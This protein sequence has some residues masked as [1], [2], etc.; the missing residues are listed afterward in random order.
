MPWVFLYAKLSEFV[1]F[2]QFAF[3][4]VSAGDAAVQ[5][6]DIPHESFHLL[7]GNGLNQLVNRV[8]AIMDRPLHFLWHLRQNM[9]CIARACVV[10]YFCDVHLYLTKM[11]GI[12]F[13]EE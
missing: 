2:L 6:L 9:D 13:R 1:F 5:V 10:L 7:F 11:Y 12:L 3:G 8:G 4:Q